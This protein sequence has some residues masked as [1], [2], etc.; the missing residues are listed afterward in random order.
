[1]EISITGVVGSCGA[2]AGV[3]H[4]S[5]LEKKKPPDRRTDLKEDS[6]SEDFQ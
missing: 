6:Q 3:T 4:R 2:A 5:A 1:M